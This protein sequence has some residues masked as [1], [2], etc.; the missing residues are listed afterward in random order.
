MHNVLDLFSGIGGFSLGLESTGGFRTAAFVE[1]DPDARKVL[2]RHW[3]DVPKYTDVSDVTGER[4]EADG[5]HGIDVICGGFPCQ[6]ISLAGKGA[7]I[8]GERSGLWSEIKRLV[9]EIH[10][11]WVIVENVA[12]LRG[13]GLDRVLR[14]IMEIGYD[15]EWHCIPASAV[16]AHHQRDSIWIVAWPMADSDNSGDGASVDDAY[17]RWSSRVED[18]LVALGGSGGCCDG[19]ADTESRRRDHRNHS[20]DHGEASGEVNASDDAG[21][22]GGASKVADSL[23]SGLE[24]TRA[25][26]K[27]AGAERRRG[28]KTYM[29]HST[30]SGLRKL[31]SCG[32]AD[33]RHI[34][35]V[36]VTDWFDDAG[37]LLRGDEKTDM[38]YTDSQR[39]QER[40]AAAVTGEPGVVGGGH[41]Q[42][43]TADMLEKWRDHFGTGVW[44]RDPAEAQPDVG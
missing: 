28:G 31:G 35:E 29:V 25:E 20:D 3:P 30:C 33:E 40:H 36:T 43:V 19:L 15:A 12:A 34:E 5:V 8:D 11:E 16:G 18:G 44:G 4:L 26:L 23:L 9:Q 39:Q 38:V 27:A 10:P 2:D 42:V 22:A 17:S 37:M 32:A 13:R 21:L 14:D 41:H 24:G 1:I 7:G 6:D